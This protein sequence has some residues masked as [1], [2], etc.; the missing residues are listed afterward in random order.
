MNRVFKIS[1]FL[2]ILAI[3]APALPKERTIELTLHSAVRIAMD[4]SYRIRQL[5]LGIERTRYWLKAERAGLKSSVYMNVTAPEISNLSEYKWNST[6][7]RDEMIRQNT[8]KVQMDLS[9]RQPVILL[10]YPTNGY[11]SLNNTMYRYIQMDEGEQDVSY[12]N[13][14]FVKFEQPFFKPNTLKNNIEQ[15]ELNLQRQELT[16]LTDQ[17]GYL[18]TIAD[19]YYNLFRLTYLSIIF[20][21]KIQNLKR[22]TGFVDRVSR[23]DTTRSIEAIQVQVELANAEERMLQNKS[24]LRLATARLKQTL[25]IDTEDDIFIN[26]VVKISPIEVDLDQATQYGLTLRPSMRTLDNSRRRDEIDLENV[27]G[28]N[29]FSMNLEMTYGIEKQDETY[30]Y[31]WEDNENSNSVTLTA[32]IPLWD[33]G[34]RKAR[35]EAYK[36]D[37]KRVDLY[38]EETKTRIESE[39]KNAISNL[40]EYQTRAL[41]MQENLDMAIEI[42]DQ[43]IV[44]YQKGKISLQDLLQNIS[45][46]TDTELNFLD[47]YLGYRRSLLSLMTNTYYDFENQISLLDQFKMNRY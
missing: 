40:E 43:S 42:T 5:K 23:E 41:N 24:E 39:I 44:L 47:A 37:I 26:P 25:R 32:Y 15:A 18:N 13:R 35:I 9:I 36:L 16:F 8:Q 6:L 22:V 30:Q 46:Q 7:Q 3:S 17:V 28:W 29:S 20:D 14:Y 2:I 1:I 11:L 38:K 45:R 12:Y 34:Q 19:S 33:W 4:N 27:K 10:G 31:L 21:H